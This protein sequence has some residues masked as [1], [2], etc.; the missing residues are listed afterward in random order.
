MIKKSA[1]NNNNYYY[2]S[3]DLHNNIYTKVCSNFEPNQTD[4]LNSV[5]RLNTF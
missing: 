3:Y 2:Y 5:F 1:K 4:P